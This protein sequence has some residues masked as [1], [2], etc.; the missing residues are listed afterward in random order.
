ME[1]ELVCIEQ[2]G[3]LLVVKHFC[4]E[5]WHTVLGKAEYSLGCSGY[6][7]EYSCVL[8]WREFHLFDFE[9]LA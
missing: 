8:L 4:L 5:Q 7:L 6:L 1:A 9:N 3:V 2:L